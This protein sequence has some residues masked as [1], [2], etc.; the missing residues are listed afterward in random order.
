VATGVHINTNGGHPVTA[1]HITKH[2]VA[3]IDIAR[4]CS[5]LREEVDLYG[6]GE[7]GR[8]IVLAIL[9]KAKKCLGADGSWC[10]RVFATVSEI[11]RG[12]EVELK[13]RISLPT[14][15][16]YRLK[17]AR[18]LGL[19]EVD[20]GR[21]VPKEWLLPLPASVVVP[22]SESSIATPNEAGDK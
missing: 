8:A 17:V 12:V 18:V 11:Q 20:H 14:I 4:A 16:K 2:S 19:R 10:A 7:V 6:L 13:R 1:I 5:W 9:R 22:D 21:G 15:R 3:R